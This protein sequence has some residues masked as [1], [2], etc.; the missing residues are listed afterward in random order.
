MTTVMAS[1]RP[2]VTGTGE[3]TFVAA[4][5]DTADEVGDV[6]VPGA[7]A[8]TLRTRRPKI[9]TSHDWRRIAGRCAEVT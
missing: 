9:V 7:F 2:G 6:I 4:V 5:T 8:S 1:A 3:V